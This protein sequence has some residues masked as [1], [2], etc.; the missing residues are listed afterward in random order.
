MLSAL[1]NYNVNVTCIIS[2]YW[3]V[4]ANFKGKYRQVITLN[5]VFVHFL[6]FLHVLSDHIS[7][8]AGKTLVFEK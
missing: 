6:L 7:G 5:G 2:V 3:V 8:Y 4:S 1:F